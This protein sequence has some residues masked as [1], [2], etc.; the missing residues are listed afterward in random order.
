MSEET[1][2]RWELPGVGFS[3]IKAKD[4]DSAREALRNQFKDPFPEKMLEQVI[5]S[6]DPAYQPPACAKH[7]R[8][9]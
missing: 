3:H 5:F 6:E 2:F 7:P 9:Q 1:W 8:N 4:K